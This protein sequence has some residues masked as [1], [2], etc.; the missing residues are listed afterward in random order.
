VGVH[1]PVGANYELAGRAAC[2]LLGFRHRD[3]HLQEQLAR[4]G[5][6]RFAGI[7]QDHV[8]TVTIEQRRADLVLQRLDLAAE[9][10]LRD[11]QLFCR[12]AEVQQLGHSFEV[13]ELAQLHF[14]GKGYRDR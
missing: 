12:A 13:T 5:V 3:V 7:R 8:G 1:P 2:D 4:G 10:G 11:V 9:R 14:A 6:K